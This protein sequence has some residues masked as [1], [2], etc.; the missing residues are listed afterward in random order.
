MAQR[1]K[2]NQDDILNYLRLIRRMANTYHWESVLNKIKKKDGSQSILFN[3]R[4]IAQEEVMNDA[5]R[6]WG[7]I[8][9]V[10]ATDNEAI[11]Q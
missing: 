3:N 1:H 8:N 7:S 2:L 5:K 9:D 6:C 10:R 11:M 4:S